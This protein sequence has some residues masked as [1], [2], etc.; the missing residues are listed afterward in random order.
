M[1]TGLRVY[2]VKNNIS[3][4]AVF[5][6]LLIFFICLSVLF[7]P[8]GSV[9]TMLQR[10]SGVPGKLW[11]LC[12]VTWP[13]MTPQAEF[14]SDIFAPLHRSVW[15]DEECVQD[16]CRDDHSRTQG[17]SN[18]GGDVVLVWCRHAAPPS[19]APPHTEAFQI[20]TLKNCW[21]HLNPNFCLLSI[22]NIFCIFSFIF[23]YYYDVNDIYT[24]FCIYK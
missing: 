9:P 10:C 16:W 19:P 5:G 12:N 17:R 6:L 7:F 23:N 24:W 4:K 11:S 21:D 2:H 13:K 8:T 20:P 1:R 18:G 14:L 22:A 15:A 3:V